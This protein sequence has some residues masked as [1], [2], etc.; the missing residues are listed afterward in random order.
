MAGPV[1]RETFLEVFLLIYL[2]NAATSWPKPEQVYVAADKALRAAANPGRGGHALSREAAH[3]VLSAREQVAVFFGVDDSRQIVFTG[4]ATDSLNMVI[5]GLA[6]ACRR[7]MVTGFEHNSVWRPLSALSENLDIAIDYRDCMT[8]CGFDWQEYKSGLALKPDLLII[9]HGS[10]ITG[11]VWPL[12]E[13]TAM[14]KA[15]G[16]LV[17][18]D[19]AQTAGHLSLDFPQLGLDFAAFPG[20]KGLLGP[21][22]IGGLYIREEQSLQ[23]VRM[24]GTGSSSASPR[25]PERLPERLESGTLNL[26]GIA[27]LA[28]GIKF[29][30][31]QGLDAVAKHKRVLLEQVRQGLD[32]L[33]ATVY[34][35][36]F[37]EA[38]ALAFNIGK[39]DSAELA[40]MLDEVYGIAVRGGL[41]C[42][43]RGH[44][45][46]GTLEQGAV[47]ISPG[48]FN[49]SEDIERFLG[50][51]AALTRQY[52]R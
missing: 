51:V 24:G 1:S 35:A 30:Q 21:P 42:S 25:Q 17:C 18:A 31:D 7:I 12:A 20:H 48:F 37:N 4:G 6:K 14:A 44:M 38:G 41:H 8:A 27:G 46:L 33:G 10:N 36:G 43:P 19:V 5:H 29:L 40:F 45:S 50:A 28:A 9:T 52:K 23:P 15:A 11:D 26:S 49:T 13:M 47:R 32:M 2:D 34:G 16:A 39:L 3:M 22:G